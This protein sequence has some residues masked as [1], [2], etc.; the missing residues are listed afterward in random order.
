MTKIDD[1][2]TVPFYWLVTAVVFCCGGAWATAYFVFGINSHL[3]SLDN[4]VH[5]MMKKLQI[6]EEASEPE[7]SSSLINN[8][9]AKTK[10]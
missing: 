1:R 9:E 8:A 10:K 4:K 2:T 3:H 7:T 5:L 6:T